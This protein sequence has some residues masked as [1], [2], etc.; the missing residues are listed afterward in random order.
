MIR[1]LGRSAF[2]S[3][4]VYAQRQRELAK[5]QGEVQ[6]AEQE[7]AA[8]KA[9][10]EYRKQLK[11]AHRSQLAA[12]VAAKN[13]PQPVYVPPPKKPPYL[14]YAVLGLGGLYLFRRFVLNK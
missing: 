13:A 3:E 14:M 7:Y 4:T 12:D 5:V 11:T 1:G 2:D 8:L 10:K 6:E 9:G